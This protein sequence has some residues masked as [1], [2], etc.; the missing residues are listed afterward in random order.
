[1]NP[2]LLGIHHVTAVARNP[3]RNLDFYTRV[4][5]LRCVKRTV[6]FDEPD[7][8]HFYFG[9]AQG[10]PGTILTFFP[11]VNK[12][13]GRLGTGQASACAFTIPETAI[14]YWQERLSERGVTYYEPVT[15]FE[16]TP[17]EEQVIV[18]RDEDGLC[19][20][21]VADRHANGVAMW[22]E[23]GVPAEA[24]VRGL[25]SVTLAEHEAG[26]TA[27]LLTQTLGF[28]KIAREENRTRYAMGEGG[29]G[30]IIDVLHLPNVPK[31]ETGPGTVHHVALRVQDETTLQEWRS[32]IAVAQFEVTG[33]RDRKYFHSIYF[34]EPGG[35]LFEIA[36][37]LPGFA[38]D[39]SP[40]D[41][42]TRLPLPAGLEPQRDAIMQKLPPLE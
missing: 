23:G 37:D 36:T 9:D 16:G 38:V 27:A 29:P 2:G 3:Q 19:V 31:G 15:R 7:T 5:G 1:M 8:Y 28:T 26:P 35:V 42:G 20:E 4:M 13:A 25:H 22:A 11:W 12:P 34:D 21:L 10:T 14:G 6:D 17:Y 33:I 41:V 18:F 32:H 39:E 40:A 24:A 30:K